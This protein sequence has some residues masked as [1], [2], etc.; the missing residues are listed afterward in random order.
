MPS[1]AVHEWHLLEAAR[2]I[3]EGEISSRELTGALQALCDGV[4]VRPPQK[5]NM[6][7]R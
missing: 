1:I 3:R 2:R 7:K 6:P 4:S 5:A